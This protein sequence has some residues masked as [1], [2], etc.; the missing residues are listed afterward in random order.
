MP[1]PPNQIPS[2]ISPTRGDEVAFS[3]VVR[4]IAASREKAIQAVNTALIDLY[5]QIVA[6]IS[7]KI[8]DAEWGDGV[9]DR[10]SKF[11]ARMEPGLRGFT[12]RK[13][14]II[15]PFHSDLLESS[16]QSP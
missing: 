3:E 10:L 11:I 13:I 6:T 2:N 14:F 1:A 8:E 5:W 16:I 9:V 4:L 15:Q 7:R 12:R